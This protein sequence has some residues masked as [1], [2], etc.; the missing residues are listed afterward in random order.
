M[1]KSA[2]STVKPL[3]VMIAASVLAFAAA[4]TIHSL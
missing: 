4:M 2:K 1:A 3:L